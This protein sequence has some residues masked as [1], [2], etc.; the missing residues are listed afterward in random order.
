MHHDEANQA[1]RFG[2]LL[3]TGDYRYDAADHHGPTLYY[4][5]LPAAW[6]RGQHTTAS[7]DERTLRLVPAAVRCRAAPAPAPARQ[8]RRA[9][10]GGRRGGAAGRRAAAHVL[11]PLL[12]PGDPAPVLHDWGSWWRRV[13]T[14]SREARAPRSGRAPSPAWRLRR[15]RPRS[16]LIPAALAGCAAARR[17]S[18]P[19]EPGAGSREARRRSGA[20]RWRPRHA[21]AAAA[22][23]PR[24]RG[25]CSTPRSSRT[26]QGLVEPFR[27]AGIYA[28]RGLNPDAHREPWYYYFRLLYQAPGG[29]MAG[30]DV[31]LLLGV[32]SGLVRRLRA[33]RG[34]GHGVLGPLPAR[35]RRDRHRRLL[36]AAVQ[37]AVERAPVLRRVGDHRGHRFG[38]NRSNAATRAPGASSWPWPSSGSAAPW[39]CNRG[40][41]T[42]ATRPI[43]GTRMLTSTRA[44]TSS[45]WPGA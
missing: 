33:Q 5:T 28:D 3:E 7:L 37:D 2:Q 13:A 23:R 45:G 38:A 8:G 4:L 24:H 41:P 19:G 12:H 27:A 43:R 20:R 32:I 1:I 30:I 25:G 36:G 14:R 22:R 31:A 15:R 29:N 18:R 44:R 40:A 26:C 35:L 17:W 39:R 16:L 21:W 34:G 11:Q 42:S 9:V 10:R 6:L